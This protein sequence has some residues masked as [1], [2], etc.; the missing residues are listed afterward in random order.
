MAKSMGMDPTN[1][2]LE[3]SKDQLIVLLRH[4]TMQAV[5]ETAPVD[6][7]WRR[8]RAERGQFDALRSVFSAI[9]IQKFVRRMSARLKMRS[10][11]RTTY[12]QCTLQAV[13]QRDL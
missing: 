2:S 11:H 7:W 4:V 12:Y 5:V 10:Y 6:D 1:E 8:L 9:K 3:I 13:A